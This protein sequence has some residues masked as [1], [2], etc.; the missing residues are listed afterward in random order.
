MDLAADVSLPGLVGL[1]PQT[2]QPCGVAFTQP[3]G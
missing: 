2:G 3:G 1:L